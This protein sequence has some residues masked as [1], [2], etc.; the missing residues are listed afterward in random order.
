MS[1]QEQDHVEA[2]LR[3]QWVALRS[4][5]DA[6]DVR[7]LG[8][9]RSVLPGWTVKEL[10]AHLGYGLELLTAVEPA[11]PNVRPGQVGDYIARYRPA[12]P[13]IAEATRE[14]AATMPDVLEGIDASA[15][16]AWRALDRLDAPVVMARRGPLTR[17][18]FL[19]TRLLEIVVH[20]DDLV[21]S[22]PSGA[23]FPVI[24]EAQVAVAQALGN[25][26]EAKSGRSPDLSD[27]LR[28]IRLATGRANSDDADLPLL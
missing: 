4:W 19:L 22:L 17:Q 2:L 25:A 15:G 3:A 23:E 5:L 9:R 10:V 20:A 13:L 1:T 27:P 7:A 24:P 26:Y 6:V 12:A 11:A 14:V 16:A 8:E 28:W 21:R 18:D